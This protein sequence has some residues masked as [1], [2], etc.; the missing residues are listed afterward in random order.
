MKNRKRSEKEKK[1]KYPS[2][3]YPPAAHRSWIFFQT[4]RNLL[5]T[6]TRHTFGREY[7]RREYHL[8]ALSLFLSTANVRHHSV[9]PGSFPSSAISSDRISLSHGGC[10]FFLCSASVARRDAPRSLSLLQRLNALPF[11]LA[12]RA[13]WSSPSP[14]R[15]RAQSPLAAVPAP[16]AGAWPSARRGCALAAKSSPCSVPSPA[17]A[18]V[19]RPTIAVPLAPRLSA[20]VAPSLQLAELSLSRGCRGVSPPRPWSC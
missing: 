18:P 10:S 9:R 12:R 1:E 3:P 6:C 19:R 17:P 20:R 7:L 13:P 4:R 14:P 8:P 5:S 2:P 15:H 11:A 16:M